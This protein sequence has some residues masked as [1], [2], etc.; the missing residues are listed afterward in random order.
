LL[1][2]LTATPRT[3]SAPA[4]PAMAAGS[5]SAFRAEVTRLYLRMRGALAS[6]DLKAFGAAYDSL[7]LLIGR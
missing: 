7:G 1:D 6:G 2:A 5:D 4:T 3:T